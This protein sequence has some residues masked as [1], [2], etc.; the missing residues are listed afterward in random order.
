M[1]TDTIREGGL[2]HKNSPVD[3]MVKEF[4]LSW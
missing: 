4:R 1:P 2:G 3:E